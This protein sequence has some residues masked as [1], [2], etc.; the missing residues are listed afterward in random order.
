MNKKAKKHT[1]AQ[2][3]APKVNKVTQN[4]GNMISE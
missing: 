3:N 2:P 4:S 1:L